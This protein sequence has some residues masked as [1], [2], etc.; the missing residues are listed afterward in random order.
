MK[1]NAILLTAG[2]LDQPNAKTAHGLIRTSSRY[3][4]IAVIDRNAAGRDAGEVLDG[5]HRDIPV[6]ASLEEFL[7]HKTP[8][9]VKAI[10]GVALP[11]GRFT[12]ELL[13]DVKKALKAG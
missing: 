1:E 3:H 5:V 11:G 2:I 13:T 8:K 7:C 12:G 4:I 10:I 9:S 6:Y